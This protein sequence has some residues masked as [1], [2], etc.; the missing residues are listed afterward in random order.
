M[1][2]KLMRRMRFTLAF[3][4]ILCAA[5]SAIAAEPIKIGFSMALTGGLAANGKA[6]LLAMQMWADDVNKKGGLLGR[7]VKLVHYDDQ[8]NPAT[9]SS[10]Y[11]KLIDF[12]KVDLV[13]SPYGT[14]LIAPAMPVVMQKGM[15]MMSLFGVGVNKQFDYDRYFQI[16]PL[17]VESGHAIPGAFF[18]VVKTVKPAPKTIA[19]VGADAEFGKVTSDA[20]RDIAKKLGLKIVYDRSYPPSTVDFAP[21]ARAIQNAGPDIVFIASY[22]ID[23]VGLYRSINEIGLKAMLVGGGAVGP[24]FAT[25]KAQLGPLLNNAVGYELYVPS[26]TMNFPGIGE[27]IALYQKEASGQ[28]IDPLGFYVPPFVYAAMEI[29]GQAVEKTKSLDQKALARTIHDNEFPTIVGNIRF[30]SNG[31]WTEPRVLMVQY[32]GIE[33]NGVDQFRDAGR[34]TILYPPAFKSGEVVLPYR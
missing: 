13:V 7:P 29:V 15:T 18:E 25:I 14:N 2:G 27:F 3:A 22:P 16:M 26:S 28:G 17:G 8:S 34:Y 33:E 10:L 21:I 5:G 19:I 11:T 9:V 4:G 12:D 30:A 20:A 24:Q 31:E 1:L 32:R 23:S 6:A